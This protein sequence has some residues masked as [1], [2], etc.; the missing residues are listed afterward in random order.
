MYCPQCLAKAIRE[1]VRKQ[2]CQTCGKTL[3]PE[4]AEKAIRMSG[5]LTCAEC[6]LA[7][8]SEELRAQR[9]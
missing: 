7:Q 1:Q 5:S 8:K 6:R 2:K 4:E 9:E 3:L